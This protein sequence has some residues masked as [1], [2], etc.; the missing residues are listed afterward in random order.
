[1]LHV[2]SEPDPSCEGSGSETMLHDAYS[3]LGSAV[4]PS[5]KGIA[6][7]LLLLFSKQS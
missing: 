5:L 6:L 2:V 1:M 3:G 7:S 4:S